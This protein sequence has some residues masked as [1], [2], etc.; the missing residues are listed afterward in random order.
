MH[1][2]VPIWKF[3]GPHF[4]V[5]RLNTDLYKANH[6]ILPERGKYGPEKTPNMDNCYAVQLY[7]HTF[8]FRYSPPS[9]FINLSFLNK[10]DA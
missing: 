1:K 8:K 3:L 6:R 10:M 5:L 9:I 2:I 4:P 7:I